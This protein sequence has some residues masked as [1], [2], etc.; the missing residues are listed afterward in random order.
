[1]DE[2]TK[3]VIAGWV[4]HLMTLAAGATGIEFLSDP[5]ITAGLV[6]LILGGGAFV[7]SWY[8]N[9]KPA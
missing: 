3:A 8:K 4:R 6:T 7:W 9:R 2:S 1:M 5:T